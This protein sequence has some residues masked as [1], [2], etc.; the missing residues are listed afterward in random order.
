[1]TIPGFLDILMHQHYRN[2]Y[3]NEHIYCLQTKMSEGN[4]FTGVCLSTAR[5]FP[6]RGKGS[7][8]GLGVSVQGGL[9]PGGGREEG[10]GISLQGREGRDSPSRWRVCTDFW[11]WPPKQVVCIPLECILVNIALCLGGTKRH[12]PEL[13][14]N[15]PDSFP[16]LQ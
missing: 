11:W 5:V 4:V 3:I 9:H 12:V 6:C 1:M 8:Y 15:G 7:P 16:M 10:E 2:I 14:S 13:H